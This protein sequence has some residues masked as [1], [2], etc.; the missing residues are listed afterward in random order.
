MP[1]LLTEKYT[2]FSKVACLHINL[3]LFQ[4]EVLGTFFYDF[5]ENHKT[6]VSVLSFGSVPDTTQC[7]AFKRFRICQYFE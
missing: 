5:M 3:T 4:L 7:T 2:W 1:R 6:E